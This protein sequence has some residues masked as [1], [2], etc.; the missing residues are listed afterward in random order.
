MIKIMAFL[1][2]RQDLSTQAFIDYYEHQHVGQLIE[3][4]QENGDPPP[5]APISYKRNYLLRDSD[6]I[7][8]PSSADDEKKP[9]FDVVTELVFPSRAAYAAWIAELSRDGG[10][11]KVEADEEN[12]LNRE[13]TMVYV[14]EER[15]T[16][17]ADVVG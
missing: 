17:S 1:S 13:R 4:K 2:K 7:I 9:G 6:A 10:W 3:K 15:V 16:R 11:G 14:V 5:H 12:F 8:A